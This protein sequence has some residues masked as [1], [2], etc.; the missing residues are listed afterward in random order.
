M[1][2][3]HASA[4]DA[5]LSEDLRQGGITV[6]GKPISVTQLQKWRRHGLID[7]PSTTSLGRYGRVSTYGPDLF[8]QVAQAAGWLSETRSL[9]EAVLAVFGLGRNPPEKHLRTA[10]QFYIEDQ[11]AS[12][13]AGID[14]PTA[15][16][17]LSRELFQDPAALGPLGPYL[18]RPVT[19]DGAVLRDEATKEVKRAVEL[20]QERVGE[21]LTAAE[22]GA[23]ALDGYGAAAG[24]VPF[25]AVQTGMPQDEVCRRLAQQG[26]PNPAETLDRLRV[27]SYDELQRE[28]DRALR[29]VRMF[30]AAKPQ[31][32]P[33]NE[34]E[35]GLSVAMLIVSSP[36]NAPE[37]VLTD[38]QW[39]E[40]EA[41]I[42][43]VLGPE[44][45]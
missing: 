33:G 41:A 23:E 43:G 42:T 12:A 18:A 15:L 27:A 9:H 21:L 7:P 14:R 2:T 38:S 28:R 44:R 6:A 16:P 40:V 13:T 32:D 20:R 5:A 22:N 8:E 11:Q 1:T 24:L 10:Y 39:Q 3:G 4:A 45:G 19:A 31:L 29:F 26:L 17:E 25:L 30:I 37:L 34:R 36:A 35:L